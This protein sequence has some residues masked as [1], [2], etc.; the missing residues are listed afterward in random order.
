VLSQVLRIKHITTGSIYD[1]PLDIIRKN[2]QFNY[3]ATA[4]SVQGSTIK[5]SM[6][7][8]DWKFYYTDREWIYT[9]VSRADNWKNIYFYDYVEPELN[10]NL[11]IAYFNG[12]ISGYKSQDN[13]AGRLISKEFYVTAEKLESFANRKCFNCRTHLYLDFKD[14]NTITNITADRIDNDIAHQLDNIRPC[15]RSCNCS[16]SDKNSN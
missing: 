12:K 5:E 16:L 6:T 15:C 11:I 10:H 7:I 3:C 14:G 13:A 8:F 2:F 1:V 4:H 9:A